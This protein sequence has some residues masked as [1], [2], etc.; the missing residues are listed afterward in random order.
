MA[1]IKHFG[2]A[3][4]FLSITCSA[5]VHQTCVVQTYN[6][7]VGVRELTGNNDG[8]EV[9]MYLKSCGLGKGYSWCAAFVKW[10]FSQ[11]GIPTPGMNAWAATAQSSV[12][13]YKN[14][15]FLSEPQP[16][17]VFTIWSISAKRVSHTGFHDHRINTSFYNTV[18]G[19]TNDGGSANG[20]GVYRR[21]RSYNQTHT[22]SRW[23]K[24]TGN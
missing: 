24:S 6:S 11:C 2:F 1:K 5:T 18:E 23:I 3:L 7:Q 12:L 14:G 10:C 22:L 19:N 20:D 9:E 4:L 16:A 15:K 17:D 8:K 21:K 13:I